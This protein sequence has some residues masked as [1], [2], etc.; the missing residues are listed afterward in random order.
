VRP[1]CACRFAEA[2][3][4]LVKTDGVDAQVLPHYGCLEGLE[5]TVLLDPALAKLQDLVLVRRRFVDECA[6]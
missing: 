5:A 3:G 1:D 4:L 6:S 2:L